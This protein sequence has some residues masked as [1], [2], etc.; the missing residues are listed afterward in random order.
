MTAIKK[1][2]RQSILSRRIEKYAR[3][4]VNCA[5]ATLMALRECHNLETG[6]ILRALS[7]FPCGTFSSENPCGAVTAGILA[8]GLAFGSEPL[9]DLKGMYDN[10]P[11]VLTYCRRIS[12][13]LGGITCRRIQKTEA[14]LS[15]DSADVSLNTRRNQHIN[16]LQ[17]CA[18]VMNTSARIADEIISA[19]KIRTDPV[20]EGIGHSVQQ[21]QTV[22]GTVTRE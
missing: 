17:R 22:G 2:T 11:Q 12:D 9:T 7:L 21:G 14:H 18:R 19:G 4:P 20:P 1:E 8:I 5:Q 10:M 16:S 13:E 6:P 15:H 3:Q